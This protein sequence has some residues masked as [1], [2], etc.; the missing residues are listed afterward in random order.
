[1]NE[2]K[3]LE[4]WLVTVIKDNEDLFKRAIDENDNKTTSDC[5]CRILAYVCVLHKIH[6]IQRA[7]ERGE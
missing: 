7:Q 4:E 1:M 6:A 2:L 5:I 3:E